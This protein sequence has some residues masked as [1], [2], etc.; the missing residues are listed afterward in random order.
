MGTPP[1]G[2]EMVAMAAEFVARAVIATRAHS[3]RRVMLARSADPMYEKKN[4][5]PPEGE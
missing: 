1:F 2:S 3:D 5:F 4:D